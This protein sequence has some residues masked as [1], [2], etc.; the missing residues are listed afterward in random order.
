MVR[1]ATRG[2]RCAAN[3]SGEAGGALP[4]KPPAFGCTARGTGGRAVSTSAVSAQAASRGPSEQLRP[5]TA[6]PYGASAHQTAAGVCP[7]SVRPPSP[8]VAE[9]HTGGAHGI[10]RA[11]TASCS[12]TSAALALSVSKTVSTSTMSTPAS[13]SARICTPYDRTMSSNVRSTLF[14]LLLSPVCSVSEN[15]VGPTEPAT[16]RGRPLGSRASASRAAATAISA[17]ARAMRYTKASISSSVGG[18][19]A[20]VPK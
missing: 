2:R 17:P 5:K 11:A 9:T 14:F 7:A 19:L 1:A 15:P 20:L 3:S 10:P 8:S 6:G 16:K 12:A 4:S 13:S 18:V